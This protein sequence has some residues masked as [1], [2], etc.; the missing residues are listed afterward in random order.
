MNDLIAILPDWRLAVVILLLFGTAPG[1]VLRVLVHLYPTGHARRRELLAE[2]YALRYVERPLFVAQ[3]LETTLFEGLAERRRTTKADHIKPEALRVQPTSDVGFA[4]PAL[5]AW[6]DKTA[7]LLRRPPQT[8]FV[9]DDPPFYG[10][11]TWARGLARELRWPF[12]ESSGV[13]AAQPAERVLRRITR[14]RQQG[15]RVVVR[16]GNENLDFADSVRQDVGTGSGAAV[17]VIVDHSRPGEARPVF[18]AVGR[19]PG[20]PPGS[21]ECQCNEPFG[22]LWSACLERAPLE[23]GHICIQDA[24]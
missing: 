9:I 21:S 5:A 16:M 2:L 1:V 20:R 23:C 12:F 14:P 7:G 3:L 18:A 11:S 15:N 13:M 17:F 10:T 4:I 19:D 24:T 8:V 6:I 22:W